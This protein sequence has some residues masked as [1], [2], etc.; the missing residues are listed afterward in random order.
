MKLL[1]K[2]HKRESGQV[3]ILVLILLLLGG[4]IIA[5]LMGFMSTGLKAGQVFEERMDEVYAADA[6]VEGAIYNIIFPG[7]PFY[8][9][10]QALEEG[11]D[12]TY[13]LP[14]LINGEAVN[15]TVT[16][17]SLLQ[18]L[19]GEDE[20]KT[21]QPHEDWV[22]FDIP[23]ENITRN[24][25]EGWVEVYCEIEFEYAGT[26]I[27]QLV[28]V[29]AY[30][31]PPPSDELLI[32]E[33]SPYDYIDPAAEP[34]TPSGVITFDDLE[35]DSP[36]TKIV[37]GGFAFIW[38]WSKTPPQGPIFYPGNTGGFSFKFKIYDPYWADPE[39]LYFIW[40]TFKEQDISYVTN[41]SGL[42]KWLIEAEAGNTTVQS[43]MLEEIGVVN[44]LTWEVNPP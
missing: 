3:L 35:A 41:A 32:S 25:E 21:G 42:Y 2:I 33:D 8:A 7:A 39:P 30:F 20:Y 29:G 1:R 22:S 23:P 34:P 19:L 16:K 12:Y 26:G 6:G 40:A 36:E 4:L 5:P 31:A 11:G 17:L 37:P 28:S 18:G 15:V 43:A 38:R 24:Y 27:R 14:T 10:L 13:S 9:A 44:I